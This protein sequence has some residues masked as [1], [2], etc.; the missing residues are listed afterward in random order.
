MHRRGARAGR[1][2]PRDRAVQRPVEFEDTW[3]IPITAQDTA[4]S[5]R[6]A[7]TSNRHHLSWREIQQRNIVRGQIGQCGHPH[8]RAHLAAQ[9][10]EVPDERIGQSLGATN[11]Q[12][13]TDRVPEHAHDQSK[14]AADRPFEWQDGVRGETSKECARRLASK[15]KPRQRSCWQD[16]WRRRGAKYH[17]SRVTARQVVEGISGGDREADRITRGDIGWSSAR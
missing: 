17:R 1:R 12:W 15:C 13:P 4:V 10:M 14:T 11:H 6:Q 3:A 16:R 5:L 2:G 9:R 8:P 7:S